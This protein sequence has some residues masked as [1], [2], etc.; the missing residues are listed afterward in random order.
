MGFK[1]QTPLREQG[2]FKESLFAKES[3]ASA[4][5]ISNMPIKDHKRM[6][7]V[8]IS[9]NK[10]PYDSELNRISPVLYGKEQRAK[11]VN[12]KLALQKSVI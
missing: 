3:I 11:R 6:F 4:D 5:V 8:N 2:E 7:V 10:E 9:Q 1:E 12:Y